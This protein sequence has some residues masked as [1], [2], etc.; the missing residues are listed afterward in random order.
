MSKKIEKIIYSILWV[1]LGVV[2]I[3]LFLYVYRWVGQNI[4]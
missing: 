1:L 2:M 4:F 3:L